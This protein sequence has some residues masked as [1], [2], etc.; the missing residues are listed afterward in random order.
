MLVVGW[1]FP[2]FLIFRHANIFCLFI[3]FFTFQ[4][5]FCSI[6]CLTSV[7]VKKR[8]TAS[9]LSASVSAVTYCPC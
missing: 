5:L 9:T 1:I 8:K 3:V 7:L 4:M 6:A 2:G